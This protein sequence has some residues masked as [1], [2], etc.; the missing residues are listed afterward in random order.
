MILHLCCCFKLLYPMYCCQYSMPGRR[1]TKKASLV[2]RS[3]PL[4]TKMCMR[5]LIWQYGNVRKQ[6]GRVGRA[7]VEQAAL[8]TGM[9]SW[10]GCALTWR[11]RQLMRSCWQTCSRSWPRV[12]P[13]LPACRESSPPRWVCLCRW[14][15]KLPTIARTVVLARSFPQ[16]SQTS[17]IF[18]RQVQ[19]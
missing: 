18:L 6:A 5:S 12:R 4:V 7:V 3:V 2:P 15:P 8:C 10:R 17:S 19:L 16:G 11:A 14:H 1:A 9:L 13:R